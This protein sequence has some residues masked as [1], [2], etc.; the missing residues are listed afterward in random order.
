MEI[1]VIHGE[2][3]FLSQGLHVFQ[4][5]HTR[6]QDE[7][8]RGTRPALLIRLCKLNLAILHVFRAHLLLNKSAAEKNSAQVYSVLRKEPLLLLS[9]SKLDY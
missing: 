5:V 3:K 9:A 2:A 1:F 4:R 7:E 6:R 8:D